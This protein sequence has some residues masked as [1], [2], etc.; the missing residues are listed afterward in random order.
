ML[1]QVTVDWIQ[2]EEVLETK[3]CRCV[4]CTTPHTTAHI[5]RFQ[6]SSWTSDVWLL[7]SKLG[8]VKYL[9]S[10]VFWNVVLDVPTESPD[11]ASLQCVFKIQ[12]ALISCAPVFV[13]LTIC[14]G[15]THLHIRS[16]EGRWRKV[17]KVEGSWWRRLVKTNLDRIY[18]LNLKSILFLVA[19]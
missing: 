11:C 4:L 7:T 3:K 1:C 17:N 18:W 13:I 19:E 12:V 8:S 14:H 2:V 5:L 6:V 16:E 9:K 15:H 10:S